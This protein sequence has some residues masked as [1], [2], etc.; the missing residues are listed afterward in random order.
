MNGAPCE[1]STS[2]EPAKTAN[3]S[4]M[5]GREGLRAPEVGMS[6]LRSRALEL[7]PLLIPS[8]KLRLKPHSVATSVQSLFRI[9]MGASG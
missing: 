5:E 7:S 4:E 6:W 1:E 3:A 9:T 8:F 2:V